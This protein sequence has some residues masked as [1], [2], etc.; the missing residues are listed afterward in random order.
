VTA[1]TWKP[2]FQSPILHQDVIRLTGIQADLS[3]VSLQHKRPILDGGE[4]DKMTWRKIAGVTV[5]LVMLILGTMIA[6]PFFMT[7]VS[8]FVGH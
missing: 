4:G 7:L 8:P 1:V 6:I 5:E 3:Q 2:G